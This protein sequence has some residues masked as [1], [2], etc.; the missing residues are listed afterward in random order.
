M[1]S[2]FRHAVSRGFERRL[3][4]LLPACTT[5]ST[6]L[7]EMLMSAFERLDDFDGKRYTDLECSRRCL[8]CDRYQLFNHLFSVHT[9]HIFAPAHQMPSA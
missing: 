7:T 8:P 3:K 9:V 5:S 1:S 6:L 2:R 4:R